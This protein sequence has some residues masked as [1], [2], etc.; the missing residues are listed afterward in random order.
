MLLAVFVIVFKALEKYKYLEPT[1][2][3]LK[4]FLSYFLSNSDIGLSQ[5]CLFPFRTILYNIEIWSLKNYICL[6]L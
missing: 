1:K 4:V 6:Q 5:K 2:V 3:S